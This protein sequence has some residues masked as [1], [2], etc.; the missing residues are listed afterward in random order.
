MTNL[1]QLD[2]SRSGARERV[3]ESAYELFSRRAVRDVGVDEIIGRA[4]VAKATFYRHF[5]GKD[6]LVLAFLV[7]REERWTFGF[8]EAEARRR[9]ATPEEQLLAIFDVFDEWFRTDDF[10]ACSF[11]NILLE[12]GNGHAVGSAS[13]R[14]LATIRTVVRKLADEAGLREPEE[15]AHSWHILMK[16]SIVAAAEGDADA[17]SRAQSI[18]RLLIDDYR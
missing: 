12:M 7:L 10:E 9:G 3:L 6:D 5:P 13:T 1:V 16:G 2:A 14:H 8:V 17:A 4:G 15:F 18:A 11:I